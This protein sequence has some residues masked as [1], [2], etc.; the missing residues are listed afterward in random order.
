MYIENVSGTFPE[1]ANKQ[2]Y[3]TQ[4]VITPAKGRAFRSREELEFQK[5]NRP[6]LLV[7]S[8][9]RLTQKFKLINLRFSIWHDKFCIVYCGNHLVGY[10]VGVVFRKYFC[11]S[12][13]NSI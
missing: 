4:N 12:E 7:P 1:P 10:A 5:E 6:Q 2:N 9:V 13:V 3:E 8:S 11:G